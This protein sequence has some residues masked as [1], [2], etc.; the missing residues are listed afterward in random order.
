MNDRD[1]LNRS[2][3]TAIR[4]ALGALK[5]R[6]R[7]S[8]A[9]GQLTAPE[10][11]ALA[12]IDRSGPITIADLARHHQITPQ[13][14]GSTVAALE[15]HG[16]LQRSPDPHDGRRSLLTVN[17]AGRDILHS[18]RDAI[19]DRMAVT[20]GESFTDSEVATLAAAA[21]LLERLTQRL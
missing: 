18:S 8:Q 1:Q 4:V 2:T 20:L 16:L 21:P 9:E 12:Q 14:M 3:A 5:R 13:A 10:V 19:S 11:S 6:A 17:D 15:K 7:E